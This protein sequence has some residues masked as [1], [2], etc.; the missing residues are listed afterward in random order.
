MTLNTHTRC[1][2]GKKDKKNTL[3]ILKMTPVGI[4]VI[5]AKNGSE[6]HLI[7]K[8]CHHFENW[9]FCKGYSKAKWSTVI[10]FG[11]KL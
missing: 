4:T 1:F 8:K 11:S 9:P 7:F 5:L 10:Y 6:T 3:N 2:M